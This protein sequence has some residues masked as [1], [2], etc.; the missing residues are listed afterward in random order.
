MLT[1]SIEAIPADCMH[2]QLIEF[3]R[4]CSMHLLAS[5]CERIGLAIYMHPVVLHDVVTFCWGRR[6]QSRAAC[7]WLRNFADKALT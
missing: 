7:H 5:R 6:N 4:M 3:H 2:Q 1:Q